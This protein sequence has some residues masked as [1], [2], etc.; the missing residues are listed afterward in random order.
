LIDGHELEKSI[1][2]PSTADAALSYKQERSIINRAYQSRADDIVGRM[3][4][5][6]LDKE[7]VEHQAAPQ[8]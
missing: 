3:T 1:Y 2:G 7:M 6:S 4:M 8:K 5:V